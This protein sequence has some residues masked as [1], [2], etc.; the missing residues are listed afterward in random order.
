M[1]SNE[2]IVASGSYFNTPN[3]QNRQ[4]TSKSK[5]IKKVNPSLYLNEATPLRD[6]GNERKK[7]FNMFLEKV[8]EENH[9]E[10]SPLK[11]KARKGLEIEDIILQKRN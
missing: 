6:K 3:R 11:Q 4:R 9:Q 10:R 7:N 1:P 2:K 8:K 5:S